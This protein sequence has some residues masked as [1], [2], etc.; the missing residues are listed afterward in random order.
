MW[1]LTVISD[2]TAEQIYVMRYKSE[3][4]IHHKEN[5]KIEVN[6]D[7]YEGRIEF[8]G[9]SNLYHLRKNK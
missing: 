3:P 6:G 2:V 9:Y 8:S 5:G 4:E 7:M 1:E